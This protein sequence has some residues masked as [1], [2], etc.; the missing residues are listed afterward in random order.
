MH[1][2]RDMFAAAERAAIS[3]G[4]RAGGQLMRTA[5]FVVVLVS[6][7]CPAIASAQSSLAGAVKDSS[8]A[9]LPGVAGE[10]SRPAV[11]EK[12]RSVVTDTTGQYKIVDLGPGTYAI[13]FS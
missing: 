13:T 9:Q 4:I 3:Q 2:S 6:I 1:I 11:I 5:R 7:L 12:V 10:G 8:G